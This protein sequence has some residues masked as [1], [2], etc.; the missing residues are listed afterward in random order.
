MDG[1]DD[2][3]QFQGVKAAFDT[4]GMDKEAQMQVSQGSLR[5]C[6]EFVPRDQLARSGLRLLPTIIPDRSWYSFC[7]RTAFPPEAL[8]DSEVNIRDGLAFST[9]APVS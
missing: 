5:A 7:T 9:G 8:S 4:I 2:A 6:V 3:V 1:V